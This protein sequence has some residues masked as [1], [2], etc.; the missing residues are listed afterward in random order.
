MPHDGESQRDAFERQR[1]EDRARRE[2]ERERQEQLA[3][4]F[5]LNLSE[6]ETARDAVRRDI[7]ARR[8]ARPPRRSMRKNFMIGWRQGSAGRRD[9]GS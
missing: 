3:A 9:A 8:E 2:R 4:K 6:D 7:A 1:T 5:G